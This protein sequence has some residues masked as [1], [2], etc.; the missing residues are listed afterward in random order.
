[1]LLADGHACI[2]NQLSSIEELL[3]LLVK[4]PSFIKF[5]INYIYMFM[6][7]ELFLSIFVYTHA[8]APY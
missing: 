1:M 4:Q 3:E 6:V 8:L 2:C 7:Y 5:I